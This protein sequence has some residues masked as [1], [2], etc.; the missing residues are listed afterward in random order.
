[1]S[2]QPLLIPYQFLSLSNIFL[3]PWKGFSNPWEVAVTTRDNESPGCIDE[4]MEADYWPGLFELDENCKSKY[5][6]Q[7]GHDRVST[8]HGEIRGRYME[9]GKEN[10][11]W[12]PEYSLFGAR[13]G[14]HTGV[15][16]YAPV[17]TPILATVDGKLSYSYHVKL[18]LFA[19]LQYHNNDESFQI[20][21]AHLSAPRN[22]FVVDNSCL[23][24]RSM[25]V[26]KGQLIGVSGCSGNAS[27]RVDGDY[28]ENE[29]PVSAHVH[30]I[31]EPLVQ[32][33]GQKERRLNP[34]DV[35]GWKLKYAGNDKTLPDFLEGRS[36]KATIDNKIIDVPA[37]FK[38][39]VTI[40]NP[41]TDLP[42]WL[43]T[44]YQKLKKI[45]FTPPESPPEFSSWLWKYLSRPKRLLLRYLVE[46]YPNTISRKDI[47]C[48]IAAL[49]IDDWDEAI[50][51]VENE[52]FQ[53]TKC[54]VPK[55]IDGN[56][57]RSRFINILKAL[58]EQ[59]SK[60]IEND[61]KKQ[62][63][64]RVY[65][66]LKNSAPS[67]KIDPYYY[68]KETKLVLLEDLVFLVAEI[69]YVA[70]K[71]SQ[72][73]WSMDDQRLLFSF[74]PPPQGPVYL[75]SVTTEITQEP[76]IEILL[77]PPKAT[78]W[79]GSIDRLSAKARFLVGNQGINIHE[80]A[81]NMQDIQLIPG[82]LRVRVEVARL[83]RLQSTGVGLSI[84]GKV[85]L[86][87]PYSLNGQIR[88]GFV[89]SIGRKGI[90][91]EIEVE[92]KNQSLNIGPLNLKLKKLSLVLQAGSKPKV[93]WQLGVTSNI[94]NR[95]QK[96]DFL[97][98]P[99]QGVS[100]SFPIPMDSF[101]KQTLGPVSVK[102]L[103][104][105][106]SYNGSSWSLRMHG[107]VKIELPSFQRINEISLPHVSL[108]FFNSE[109]IP[110]GRYV[111]PQP[112][113]VVIFGVTLQLLSIEL[114]R[115]QENN[116]ALV[117]EG[118]ASL[119]AL[120]L[121][122]NGVKLRIVNNQVYI[123][124]F[125]IAFQLP[126]PP[127]AARV[128][129]A[130]AVTTNNPG[131]SVFGALTLPDLN[132]DG[133][134]QVHQRN[135]GLLIAATTIFPAP[136]PIMNS[137][138]GFYSADVLFAKDFALF[139]QPDQTWHQRLTEKEFGIIPTMSNLTQL[140]ESDESSSNQSI[141]KFKPRRRGLVAAIGGVVGTLDNGTLLSGQIMAIVALP[142]MFIIG[143]RAKVFAQRITFTETDADAGFVFSIRLTS[144]SIE[145]EL[146][147]DIRVPSN[148]GEL[149]ALQGSASMSYGIHPSLWWIKLGR[150]H[151]PVNARIL[152]FIAMK[153]YAELTTRGFFVSAESRTELNLGPIRGGI[154]FAFQAGITYRPMYFETQGLFRAWGS[155]RV[156]P[157]MLF[158]AGQ[159]VL[160]I[161]GPPAYL[162]A[163]LVLKAGAS[164][165]I[166]RKR[167]TFSISVPVSVSIG[168]ETLPQNLSINPLTGEE[169]ETNQNLPIGLDSHRLTEE[170]GNSNW[171]QI[172]VLRRLGRIPVDLGNS[173]K[174]KIP[175]DS[176]LE[177]KFARPVIVETSDS[178]KGVPL[179]SR[180]D[181]S[182]DPLSPKIPK[183]PFRV[184]SLKIK[185]ILN[186]GTSE[187]EVDYVEAYPALRGDTIDQGPWAGYSWG[188]T[189]V[190]ETTSEIVL[191]DNSDQAI[192]TER[193]P[194]GIETKTCPT[195]SRNISIDLWKINQDRGMVDGEWYN[196][197]E[198]TNTQLRIMGFSYSP[199]GTITFEPSS[200]WQN[201]RIE[202]RVFGALRVAPVK[203]SYQDSN[204]EFWFS[205]QPSTNY[206]KEGWVEISFNRL[207]QIHSY[208]RD[209][210]LYQPQL[211]VDL[212][213]IY[214]EAVKDIEPRG[215]FQGTP[216][217]L[218]PNSQFRLNLE[219][220]DLRN[221]GVVFQHLIEFSTTKLTDGFHVIEE[222]TTP[223]RSQTSPVSDSYEE[224]SFANTDTRLRLS[225]LYVSAHS[226][227]DL[228][229]G[230]ALL[231][232][233]YFK[234]ETIILAFRY[235]WLA[236]LLKPWYGL[237]GEVDVETEVCIIMSEG[238]LQHKIMG[239]ILPAQSYGLS[240]NEI[241]NGC[242]VQY[243]SV[244]AETDLTRLSFDL[245]NLLRADH[246]YLCSLQIDG[247]NLMQFDLLT[248]EHPN[249]E[250][251]IDAIA[252]KS[253]TE[254]PALLTT[255]PFTPNQLTTKTQT[256]T[257]VV[258]ARSLL[259][260]I[261][262]S[263]RN[264]GAG[265]RNVIGTPGV[266]QEISR[267]LELD[268]HHFPEGGSLLV[269][270]APEPFTRSDA[271]P[272]NDITV[273]SKR[274]I[275][276]IG[277][278][279]KISLSRDRCVLVC[280][281]PEGTKWCDVG[282]VN[283]NTKTVPTISEQTKLRVMFEE[284]IQK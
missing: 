14:K 210:P 125:G 281:V 267:Q 216:A 124:N 215:F 150:P 63:L 241:T 111:F 190:T 165:R 237:Q 263:Q 235:R 87:G 77:V 203:A 54:K 212:T 56:P 76:N 184:T 276:D 107:S 200:D 70:L 279:R 2:P 66:A 169:D 198:D 217:V 232:P 133:S 207:G 135:N 43:V 264:R 129:F 130:G 226:T 48:F 113:K 270:F 243:S 31:V 114:T 211:R 50:K 231:K 17:G 283:P 197:P 154:L 102:P 247:K 37:Q 128:R 21:Y 83:P 218:R 69:N 27:D 81:S 34:I 249:H 202:L 160:D 248:S 221:S 33:I 143:G 250:A 96:A 112:L 91:F 219:C 201:F 30:L 7:S 4:I 82:R 16:I 100:F 227:P 93:S 257:T 5:P 108:D 18:G 44:F 158:V 280:W 40:A 79:L 191:F 3:I 222:S 106:I 193:S 73:I 72:I 51:L 39:A 132:L 98:D 166:F 244:V 90:G 23:S 170:I 174:P 238:F 282:V 179:Y 153:A 266:Y 75:H 258:E 99:D 205:L 104:A 156:G 155:A 261:R 246:R 259:A 164:I 67:A 136:R 59:Y 6:V 182:H 172:G 265:A 187:T 177:I 15:D 119:P 175:P 162:K 271:T 85:I 140:D 1:V 284:E 97:V 161:A 26:K 214:R 123:E 251:F 109:L 168:Q 252:W 92:P 245:T 71:H 103:E 163:S 32:G 117:L 42:P 101:S 29:W 55:G 233:L 116:R 167:F 185:L 121:A 181:P 275:Q 65:E 52:L 86:E 118:E 278:W 137:G 139:K 204:S 12:L 213:A 89:G 224:P 95:V 157:F 8:L 242:N 115:L 176:L 120:G 192:T 272:G 152:G 53:S 255:K 206:F 220:K 38:L 209:R 189:R 225:D 180:R 229:F 260:E 62:T 45:S 236:E 256:C 19:L 253:W 88:A 273:I 239:H 148:N 68:L 178:N 186:N 151:A 58:K 94:G 61:P 228:G 196:G 254:E 127:D 208:A 47:S 199:R 171:K 194:S 188:T 269:L 183:I 145:G 230:T 41:E 60:S 46:K 11:L 57:D 195:L 234:T 10:C 274:E 144:R 138:L 24:Q 277:E 28:S 159:A 20:Y 110:K 142:G 223:D 80:I 74:Q 262:I 84:E 13:G 78:N 240:V 49:V 122:V 35:F 36:I 64:L 134:A 149:L 141:G 131:I 9:A 147:L 22:D 126:F 173:N 105:M 268:V 146:E 25:P